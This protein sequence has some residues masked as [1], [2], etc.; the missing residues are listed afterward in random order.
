MIDAEIMV[1][2]RWGKSQ[3]GHW[4]LLLPF[5]LLSFIIYTQ[6]FGNLLVIMY[7]IHNK[8]SKVFYSLKRAPNKWF[9]NILFFSTKTGL[10]QIL[11]AWNLIPNQ[12]PAIFGHE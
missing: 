9:P 12:N 5:A 7:N 11:W 10:F 2:G 1:D 8:H 6:L 3:V 4:A